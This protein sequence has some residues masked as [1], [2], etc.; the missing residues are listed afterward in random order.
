MLTDAT[1]WYLG[2]VEALSGAG[3]DPV[4]LALGLVG[5]T[6][7]LE[8]AA[9]A[10]GV[11]LAAEGLIGVPLALVAVAGGIAG[12]DLLL[13]LLGHAGRRV[14]LV[15]RHVA[16]TRASG[17]ARRLLDRNLAAAVLLARVVPGLRLAVYTASGLFAV[18]FV[19][20]AGLVVVAVALWTGLI[21]WLGSAASLALMHHW[22]IPPGIAA[23]ALFLVL[24]LAPTLARRLTVALRRP[25]P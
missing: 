12:G 11:F 6:L 23:V 4:A 22:G 19:P 2:V 15:R 1:T 14:S 21:F 17:W 9:I 3:G 10:A 5:L 20:F 24:A 13:Y 25:G 7:L 16:D 18:P 8:D